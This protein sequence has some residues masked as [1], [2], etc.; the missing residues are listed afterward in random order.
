MQD[1]ELETI[2]TDHLENTTGGGWLDMLSGGKHNIGTMLGGANPNG[3]AFGVN[4]D[5]KGKSLSEGIAGMLGFGGDGG[6]K[7]VEGHDHQGFGG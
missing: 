5:G 2:Q 4:K 6:F 3:G 7:T 1:I